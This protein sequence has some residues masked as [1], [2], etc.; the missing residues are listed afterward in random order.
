MEQTQTDPLALASLLIGLFSW[1]A[2]CCGGAIFPLI[3]MISVPFA[4]VG[5]VLG[6]MSIKKISGAPEQWSG[7]PIAII[8]IVINVALLL[9]MV[10]AAVLMMA[11]VGLFMMEGM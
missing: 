10:V 8:G 4:L 9:L 1:M 5:I 2:G 11:G 3:G 7:K 6:G